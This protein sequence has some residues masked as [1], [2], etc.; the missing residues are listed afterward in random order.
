MRQRYD[1]INMYIDRTIKKNLQKKL[2]PGKVI[3]LIGARR[4]GKTVLLQEVVKEWERDFIL[5]NGEDYSVHELLA[6]RSVENYRQ[7]LG[8]ATLLA[9]DEAHY[10]PEIG[11]IL[12]LMIDSFLHLHIIITGSSAFD[13]TGQTGEPLTGRKITLQLFPISEVEINPMEDASVKMDKM[14]QRLVFGNLPELLTMNTHTEKSTYLREL[15]NSYLLKDILALDKIRNSNKLFNLLKLIAFQV[16]S[17][18]S[19][20]ELGR[21]CQM[22]KNTVERYL[23]ILTK[24]FVL[25]PLFGFNRNLRKEVT[26]SNKW[27]FYDNGVRNAIIANFSLIEMRN[28]VGRLW[29]NYIISERLK[30]QHSQ[31]WVVNNYFWRTYDGQEI[32]WVE[33]RN[34][35]LS[36]FEFKWSNRKIKV[37]GGWKNAYPAADFMVISKDNYRQFVGVL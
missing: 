29:E 27:Y 34:G 23:D 12:K 5:W 1:G 20:E 13:I 6:R 19:L 30:Y 33:D 26:K 21:K 31:E 17:E 24:I 4:V 32:D 2:Q 8:N 7:L 15:V 14:R 10:I 36:A 37:P 22:S 25:V 11:K 16:G 9:I 18:V 28:D 3:I 35:Q